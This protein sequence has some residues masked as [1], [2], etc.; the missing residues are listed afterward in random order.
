MIDL[1]GL[2]KPHKV[3]KINLKIKLITASNE[4]NN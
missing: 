4:E 3:K 2:L 1:A